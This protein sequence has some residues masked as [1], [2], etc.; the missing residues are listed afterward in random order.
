MKNLDNRRRK[1]TFKGYLEEFKFKSKKK[2]Y[3]DNR[4][5]K[6]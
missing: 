4:R 1:L 6:T 5:S 3:T 2:A